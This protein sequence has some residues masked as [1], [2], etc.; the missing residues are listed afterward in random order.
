MTKIGLDFD[1][2]LI[3]YDNL[4]HKLAKEKGLID[5][6]VEACKIAI[7]NFLRAH[8]KDEEFTLLQGEVY[9]NRILEAE[10]AKEMIETLKH[11]QNKGITI[12]VISHKT[13]KPYK[14]P[15]YDLHEAALSWMKKHEFFSKS[16]L[17][18]D[19]ERINF[20][21]TKEAKIDRI[22]SLGCT[23]Y[24]DDLPEI[25]ESLPANINGILYD[26]KDIYTKHKGQRI[27]EWSHLKK[28]I[29]R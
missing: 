19:M 27:A 2:T 28:I 18:W 22:R 8:D 24:I 23:L 15:T 13:R 12:V 20:E 4:F 16:G 29:N 25:I 17:G 11:I 21:S 1:N 7:R 9:G 5:D 3:H 10:P 26:P 6:T 14:G